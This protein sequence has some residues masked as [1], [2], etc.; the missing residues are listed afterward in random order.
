VLIV[1][2]V[3]GRPLL[4][5]TLR[6]RG[7]EVGYAEVY[8][9][10]RP[11]ADPTPLLAR[12]RVEVDL[13]TATSAELLDNLVAMLGESGWPLLRETPLLVISERMAQ[14]ANALGFTQVVGAPG[15]DDES[16]LDALCD[17]CSKSAR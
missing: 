17:W 11:A 6:A 3:G 14:R 10:L 2:G 9:R 4:G 1:R 5:D 16:V 7:A 15:A 8:R 13:V 12:W